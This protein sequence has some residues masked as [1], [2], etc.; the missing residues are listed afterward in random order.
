MLAMPS[1]SRGHAQAGGEGRGEV[2]A[3]GDILRHDAP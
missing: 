3:A 2:H 1:P